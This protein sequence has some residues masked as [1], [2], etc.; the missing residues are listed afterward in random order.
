MRLPKRTLIAATLILAGLRPAWA[1]L[2]ISQGLGVWGGDERTAIRKTPRLTVIT[3][4]PATIDPAQVELAEIFCFAAASRDAGEQN[5]RGAR[6]RYATYAY[7]IN[8]TTKSFEKTLLD[9][10]VIKTDK[11]GRARWTT[12]IPTAQL[13]SYPKPASTSAWS[14]SELVWTNRRKVEFTFLACQILDQQTD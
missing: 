11:T 8:E 10:G 3:P 2:T 14:V 1:E 12:R 9:S 7:S 5:V 13:I 4:I 6:G